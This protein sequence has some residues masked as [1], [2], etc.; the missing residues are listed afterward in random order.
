METCGR[1]ALE[2]VNAHASAARV[3]GLTRKQ[4]EEIGEHCPVREVGDHICHR[5]VARLAGRAGR[6]CMAE[7]GGGGAM[8]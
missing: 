4:L 2:E 7:R 3:G 6:V 8:S 5:D 1:Q